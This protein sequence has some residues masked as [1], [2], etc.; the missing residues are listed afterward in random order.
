MSNVITRRL[1]KN[2]EGKDLLFVQSAIAFAWG[3]GV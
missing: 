1:D 3:E 2:S